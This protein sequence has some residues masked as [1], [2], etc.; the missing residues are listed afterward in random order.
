M[1]RVIQAIAVY[2]AF[3]LP[4][5]AQEGVSVTT[6]TMSCA[7]FMVLD[8]DNRKAAVQE[9][10]AAANEMAND[11]MMPD[12]TASD[13]ATSER[14]SPTIDVAAVVRAC[15]DKPDKM[16]MDVVMEASDH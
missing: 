14:D 6:M 8:S 1:K 7:E 4:A 2:A 10:W 13:A 15:D 11:E 16:V 12:D 5:F 9:M 3:A